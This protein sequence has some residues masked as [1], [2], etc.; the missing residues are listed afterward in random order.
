MLRAPARRNRHE[1][2]ARGDRCGPCKALPIRAG[3]WESDG[4]VREL[5]AA[6]SHPNSTTTSHY[7]ASAGD[8]TISGTVTATNGGQPLAGLSVISS[9]STVVTDPSGQFTFRFAGPGSDGSFALTIS[10]SSV[11]TR[12]TYMGLNTH[13]NVALDVISEPEF[14]LNYYR[15]LA[16]DGTEGKSFQIQ[17][18]T[19]NPSVYLRTINNGG[20]QLDPQ[21][22]DLAQNTISET[23]GPWTGGQLSVASFERGTDSREGV[24]GWITVK[25]AS[26]A[27]DYCGRA[28][29]GFDG[30]YIEINPGSPGCRCAGFAISAAVVRHELGHAMGMYHTNSPNDVMYP[31]SSGRCGQLLSAHE[32]Q[33]ASY[34]Y[35]RAVG[36]TDP[37]ND[38]RS[39]VY[40]RPYVVK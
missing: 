4:S 27:T 5:L 19:K 22:L 31:E 40:S 3:L 24:S 10:G 11:I 12:S 33:Y 16:R 15:Q 6:H 32:Q 17:R 2:D 38:P 1:D 8:H 34:I 29:I 18:W 36:N 35:K 23:I 7:S 39:T 37:D 9:T 25:W 20:R 14:D 21:A 30:G 26:A 28:Q 13:S